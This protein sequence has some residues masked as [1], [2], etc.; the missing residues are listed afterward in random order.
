MNEPQKKKRN[1]IRENT[2]F[3]QNIVYIFYTRKFCK[4]NHKRQTIFDFICLSSYEIHS[5]CV[6]VCDK[7]MSK[8]LKLK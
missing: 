6:F 7:L 4:Q 8:H 3:D 1:K 2:D 5:M